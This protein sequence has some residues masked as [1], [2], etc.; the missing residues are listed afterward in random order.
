M[1]NNFYE[2]CCIYCEA[3]KTKNFAES[4]RIRQELL[5]EGIFLEDSP[6]GTTWRR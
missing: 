2:I 4:D 3:K 6:Q 5:A 1:F